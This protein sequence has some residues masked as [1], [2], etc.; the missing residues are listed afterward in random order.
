M[1]IKRLL[2]TIVV[3]LVV[4]LPWVMYGAKALNID[5]NNAVAKIQ[6]SPLKIK[7]EYAI[8]SYVMI[9][10]CIYYFGVRNKINNKINDQLLDALMIAL[11]VYGSFDLI[12]YAL[13]DKLPLS[14]AVVDMVWG[15]TSV[16]LTIIITT[17][18]IKKFN[19]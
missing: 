9:A 11:A 19:I 1:N 16:S 6:G 12:N 3:Y 13:F 2:V 4:D 14:V 17:Y 8:I 10:V 15:L 7:S 5:W 18:I